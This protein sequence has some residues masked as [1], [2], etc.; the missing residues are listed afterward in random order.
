MQTL[1]PLGLR[2]IQRQALR[3]CLLPSRRRHRLNRGRGGVTGNTPL[4]TGAFA[5]NRFVG[6]SCSEPSRGL[7]AI[8]KGLIGLD[9]PLDQRMPH[10]VSGGEVRKGQA[11]DAIQHPHHMFEPGLG[12]RRQI[13]LRHITGDHHG[14]AKPDPGQEHFHLLNGCILTFVQNNEG[15]VQRSDPAYRPAGQLR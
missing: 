8:F 11:F 6:A 14:R 12:S 7:I 3:L 13:H 5:E 9:N 4:G 10:N 1:E 15:I 2:K